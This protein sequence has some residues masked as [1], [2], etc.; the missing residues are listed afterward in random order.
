M[1]FEEIEIKSG[2]IKTTFHPARLMIIEV[3]NECVEGSKGQAAK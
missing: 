2:I 3:L 1:T